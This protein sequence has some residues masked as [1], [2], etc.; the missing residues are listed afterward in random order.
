MCSLV[1]WIFCCPDPKLITCDTLVTTEDPYSGTIGRLWAL[2]KKEEPGFADVIGKTQCIFYIVR[3]HPV[4]TL[5]AVTVTII[6]LDS[7]GLSFSII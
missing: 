3:I 4:C 1:D 7:H 5:Q 2:V 6:A